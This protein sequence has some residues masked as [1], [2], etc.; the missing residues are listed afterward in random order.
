[1]SGNSF[2]DCD[3]F[4]SETPMKSESIEGTIVRLLLI[5]S[6]PL[7]LSYLGYLGCL[8]TADGN[9]RPKGKSRK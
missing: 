8:K 2:V 9:N 5:L 6:F 3:P 7:S 4:S 1:M